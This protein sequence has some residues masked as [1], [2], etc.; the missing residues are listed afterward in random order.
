M[1]SSIR[2]WRSPGAARSSENH[3]CSWQHPLGISHKAKRVE[4]S[5]P[6]DRLAKFSS[7]FLD[8]YSR[9][10][11]AQYLSICSISLYGPAKASE[12][13]RRSLRHK[14]KV[15]SR[16]TYNKGRAI[17]PTATEAVGQ[18]WCAGDRVVSTAGLSWDRLFFVIVLGFYTVWFFIIFFTILQFLPDLPCPTPPATTL[19]L[20][21]QLHILSL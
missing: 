20:S 6:S 2:F 21:T 18:H 3:L 16:E 15:F 4:T 5:R 8:A 12:K 17:T 13:Q 14:H 1:T 7:A 9:S 19:S 11:S 10:L